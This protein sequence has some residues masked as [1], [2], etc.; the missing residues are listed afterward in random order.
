MKDERG[1]QGRR[2]RRGKGRGREGKGREG[3]ERNESYRA[4][5]RAPLITCFRAPESSSG[6][7]RSVAQ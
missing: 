4:T 7:L 5:T 3:N 2:E 6:T 1:G